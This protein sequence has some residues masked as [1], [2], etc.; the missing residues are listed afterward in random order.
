MRDKKKTKLTF[1]SENLAVP[2]IHTGEIEQEDELPE[3]TEEIQYD[4]LAIPEIHLK[5][6]K[7][8]D[9]NNN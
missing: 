2:E 8:P 4:T 6:H 3:D 1:S 7:G 9:T 5:K